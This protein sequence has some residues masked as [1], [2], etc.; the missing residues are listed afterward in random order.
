MTE[1]KKLELE[2]LRGWFKYFNRLLEEFDCIEC[3]KI[4]KNK[5]TETM[6][7]F[8]LYCEKCEEQK[9]KCEEQKKIRMQA[10]R[11]ALRGWFKYCNRLLEEFDCVECIKV[12]NNKSTEKRKRFD[13]I[14]E[15]C[16]EQM[17]II[18]QQHRKVNWKEYEREF[19][20]E[21]YGIY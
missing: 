9:K 20:Q 14:C 2:E 19:V 7:H 18:M 1:L 5:S 10:Q 17:E 16:E 6:K 11:D 13:L 8:D 3:I 15:K 21:Y 4:N 12:N